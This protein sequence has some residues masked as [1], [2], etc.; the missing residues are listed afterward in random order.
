MLLLCVLSIAS[1]APACSSFPKQQE[2]TAEPNAAAFAVLPVPKTLL[3]PQLT[4]S[5]GLLAYS[6]GTEKG[7]PLTMA[8]SI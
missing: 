6:G 1:L 5:R 2:P 3:F 8:S 4:S 7:K